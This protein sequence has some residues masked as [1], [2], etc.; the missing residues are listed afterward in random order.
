[1]SND[2]RRKING[3]TLGD[4]LSTVLLIWPPS[5]RATTLRRGATEEEAKRRARAFMALGWR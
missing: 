1:M 4:A 2:E 3:I 5:A